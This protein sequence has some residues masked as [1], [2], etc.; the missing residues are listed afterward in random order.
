MK[1]FLLF[2]VLIAAQISA[3]ITLK[4]TAVPANTPAG[5]T[6]YVAGNFNGWNPAS[7]PM[8]SD[9]SGNYTYTIPE[10]SGTLEY[11]FTRG[12][13]ATV[14]G[15]A[16]GG[17]LP[18]RTA[19]FTG[20]AQTLNHTIQTWED[21]GAGNPS[22]AASNVHILSTDFAIPQ[23]NRTRKIWIYLPPDY[24][25][26]TKKYPVLY[27]Q[28]GQNIFDNKTAYS[29]EWQIDE[30]LNKLFSEGDYG[31]IVIG[32]D[33]GG[34]KRIDEYTPWNNPKYGGGEGDLYM[35]FIAETLKPYVDSH[36][37][38]RP[39]KEFNALIGSSLGALISNYGG[40]KY[41][42][43]FG[44]IG[45]F[46]PAYW[47]VSQQFNDFIANSTADLSRTRIYFV[48]GATESTTMAADI[49][50]VKNG[51]E[52]DGLKAKNTLVKLDSYGQHNENYWKGEFAAAY[53]WLFKTT[54]LNTKNAVKKKLVVGFE[55]NQ[56]YVE[57]LTQKS[58][59]KI[60]DL[61]GRLLEKVELK[62]GWNEIKNTLKKGHY[63]LQTENAA[64]RFMSK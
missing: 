2:L 29:G 14:E 16:T 19:T 60:Y 36:Y 5:A 15:N 47:I 40:V 30:T 42:E 23:L 9:G 56:I 31:A 6:I 39:E 17:Q 1:R 45:S 24:E 3:Q 63:I 11:K 52:A 49:A 57:G 44:K 51:M 37:R 62:N 48:A 55:K 46:S 38:T 53:Q 21:L 64:V 28:D 27:M 18:N 22:T 41:S 43:T 54:T 7:T 59:A 33:N 35:Q 12:S 20:S 32:I 61:S 58:Q 50:A 4:I 8:V 10:G 25:T 26:S 13:W 34:E